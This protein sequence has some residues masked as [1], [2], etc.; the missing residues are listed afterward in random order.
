MLCSR[1]GLHDVRWG[2]VSVCDKV[3]GKL[4]SCWVFRREVTAMTG[5]TERQLPPCPALC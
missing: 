4:V 3:R 2:T 5:V 1:S